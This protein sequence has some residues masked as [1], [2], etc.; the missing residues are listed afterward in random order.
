M[1]DFLN[2]F[3]N[4]KYRRGQEDGGENIRSKTTTIEK[5]S[6][7]AELEDYSSGISNV[8]HDVEVDKTFYKRK[9]IRYIIIAVTAVIL[10]LI[11][12]IGVFLNNRVEVRDLRGINIEEARSWALRSRIELDIRE[13]FSLEANENIIIAQDIEPNRRISRRSVLTVTV[14]RGADPDERVEIPDFE[15]MTYAQI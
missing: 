1:S 6:M 9:I 15:E 7:N 12:S 3:S 13:E 5:P 8:Y 11:V 14:S 4:D 2:Q 10:T